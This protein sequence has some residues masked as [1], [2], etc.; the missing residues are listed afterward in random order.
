MDPKVFFQNPQNVIH[1]QYVALRMYFLE[2]KTAQEVARQ[3]GYEV[4]AVYAL[5]YD[6]K[7]L[8]KTS[9]GVEKFFIPLSLGRKPKAITRVKPGYVHKIAEN[10]YFSCFLSTNPYNKQYQ[11]FT[12]ILYADFFLHS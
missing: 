12:T 2:N 9:K 6:F 8:L 1:K 7:K 5:T 4:N 10:R 3:F 11:N